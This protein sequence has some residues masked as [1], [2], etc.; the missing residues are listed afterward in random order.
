MATYFTLKEDGVI[1]MRVRMGKRIDGVVRE[2]VN[3]KKN[4]TGLY[5]PEELWRKYES[6]T[7]PTNLKNFLSH[8]SDFSKTIDILDDIRKAIDFCGTEITIEKVN[9][10]VRDHVYADL[11]AKQKEIEKD[12]E[13]KK[14]AKG[15]NITIGYYNNPEAT[16][17]AF[18]DYGWLKTGDLGI[19]DADGNIFIRGRSKNMI[20][21]PSGQNIYP[22][23]RLPRC[24]SAAS[25]T[26]NDAKGSFNNA[27]HH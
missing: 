9:E 5:A 15:D 25:S 2:V 13:E 18:T 20:L 11:I 14:Q 19:M 6:Y 16:A 26:N 8:N 27:S 22:E 10:I 3:I 4:I 21:G 12:A 17:N 7:L 1:F 24:L 23:E